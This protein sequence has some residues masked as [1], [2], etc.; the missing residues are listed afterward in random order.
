MHRPP[1]YLRW[2]KRNQGFAKHNGKRVYFPG[3]YGSEE[4]FKAYQAWLEKLER[5]QLLEDAPPDL[6]LAEIAVPYLEHCIDYYGSG[7]RSTTASIR[8]A[9]RAVTSQW[10]DLEARKITPKVLKAIRDQMVKDGL[11]RPTVNKRLGQIKSWL[12]WAASEELIE[13]SVWHACNVVEGL[14]RGRSAAQEPEPRQPVDWSAV[15]PVLAELPDVVKAMVMLQWYTGARSGSIV[16]AQPDQ[17]SDGPDGL[18]MWAPRHKTEHLGKSLVIPIGPRCQAA[19]GAYLVH[20]PFCFSPKASSTKGRPGE[21]YS[22]WS[23]RR[24]IIRAQERLEIPPEQHWTP[25]QLRHARGHAVRDK[26][27]IEAAQAVLG[28]ESLR[29][30]EI[31]SER[32]LTLAQQV[33]LSDG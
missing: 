5:L 14:K 28:H 11:A 10:A 31:Y 23:Y 26:W 3:Q 30:T 24:A 22:P 7:P 21:R 33:A 8:L 4:S 15:K 13:P 27:G 2:G 19:V 1:R 17:F 25:H 12:K 6:T 29:T 16:M 32:R 20:Q 9:I 18:L